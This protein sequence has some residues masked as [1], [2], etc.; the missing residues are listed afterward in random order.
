[1]VL[2]STPS[3]SATWRV[4]GLESE[5]CGDGEVALI[6]LPDTEAVLAR[7]GRGVAPVSTGHE[8]QP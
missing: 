6:V 3:S 4:I 5:A 2:V 7:W 8:A 1:M